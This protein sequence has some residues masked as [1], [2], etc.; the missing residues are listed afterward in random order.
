MGVYF[1]V[2]INGYKKKMQGLFLLLG[3]IVICGV[4]ILM[5]TKNFHNFIQFNLTPGG[6]AKS[7]PMKTVAEQVQ[8]NKD[9]RF[10]FYDI[11]DALPNKNMLWPTYGTLLGLIRRNK[12]I[13]Y[14][15]DVDLAGNVH[16]FAAVTEALI[17]KLSKTKYGVTIFKI[18]GL[19]QYCRQ[20]FMKG[21]KTHADIAFYHLDAKKQMYRRLVPIAGKSKWL[22]H[23]QIYPLKPIE[24]QGQDIWVPNDPISLL[25]TEYG[26]NWET[27][28]RTELC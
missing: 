1:K 23:E 22:R 26:P 18:P 12:L 7:R 15:D 3:L 6:S 2:V 11:L 28:D 16:D 5:F 21:T 10:L 20:V 17:T 4:L 8:N 13:C 9:L 14:D 25:E 24:Y 19:V 27:P